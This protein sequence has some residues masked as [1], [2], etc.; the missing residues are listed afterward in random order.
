MRMVKRRF[1]NFDEY[2]SRYRIR[3]FSSYMKY[4][5]TSFHFNRTLCCSAES[6][7][8]DNTHI[9]CS[10]WKKFVFYSKLR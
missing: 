3:N 6:I 9:C 10:S 8:E 2:F 5:K 7:K 1:F 4:N